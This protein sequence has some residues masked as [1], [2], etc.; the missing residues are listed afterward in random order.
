LGFDQSLLWQHTLGRTREGTTHDSRYPNP[1]LERNGIDRDFEVIDYADVIDYNETKYGP[2]ILTRFVIDFIE[3]QAKAGTP[4]LA[5]YAMNLPHCPFSPTPDSPDWDPDSLGSIT[6]NGIGDSEQ[7]NRHF[8]EMVAYADKMVGRIESKLIEL[9]IRENT[10]IMFIGDNG[11][12]HPIT[13]DWNG[14]EVKGGK[15]KLTDNGLR[16][17]FIANWPGTI[18]PNRVSKR[19]VDLSDI[20]PTFCEIAGAPLPFGRVIDGYSL[21]PEMK[22]ER[23]P[24]REFVYIYYPEMDDAQER[25]LARTE[26]YMLRR[27]WDHSTDGTLYHFPE[28]YTMNKVDDADMTDEQAALKSDMLEL[29]NRMNATRGSEIGPNKLPEAGR[30]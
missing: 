13:T 26:E 9:G 28:Q 15:R 25:I 19:L 20:L 2:D 8:G 3:E 7:W 11:T 18:S 6:Y 14:I 24:N 1:V 17:P 29:I 10:L 21:V 30:P 22:G 23:S 5:Y 16:V 12:D 4:F 27:P